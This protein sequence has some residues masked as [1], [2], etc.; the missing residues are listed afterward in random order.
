[1]DY[2]QIRKSI[3][4]MDDEKLSIEDLK[5]LSKQL[6]TSEEVCREFPCIRARLQTIQHF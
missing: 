3:V 2:P 1:M 4:E 6:P 5:A